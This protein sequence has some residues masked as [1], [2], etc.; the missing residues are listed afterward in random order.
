MRKVC[1]WCGSAATPSGD[2]DHNRPEPVSHG[3]CEEC[4]DN[5]TFQNGVSLQQYIDSLPLPVLVLD[6]DSRVA[7]V[8]STACK[9]LKKEPTAILHQLKGNVFECANSRLPEGCGRT[10]HCSGCAI[11]RAVTET[12]ETGKPQNMV[13]ATLTFEEQEHAL[14]ADLMITTVKTKDFVILRLDRMTKRTGG[15]DA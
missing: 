10:I 13:P 5:F 7:A 3:I 2:G 15:E 8:N 12:F 6:E 4:R 1:A 11:R 14:V 9:A